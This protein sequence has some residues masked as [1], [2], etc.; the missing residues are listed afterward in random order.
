MYIISGTNWLISQ[1][2]ISSSDVFRHDI[3]SRLGTSLEQSRLAFVNYLLFLLTI[4]TDFSVFKILWPG[5]FYPTLSH[6]PTSN[7]LHHLHWS[8]MEKR[9]EFKLASLTF[10]RLPVG[11]PVHLRSLPHD[12]EPRRSL[13]SSNRHLLSVPSISSESGRRCFSFAAPDLWNRLPLDRRC[14]S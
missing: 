4:Y 9:V 2:W 6:L 7:L 5:W 10:K 1:E 3:S 14:S 13:R 8:P 12:Y 11:Q